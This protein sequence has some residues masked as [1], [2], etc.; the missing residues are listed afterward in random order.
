MHRLRG[1]QWLDL[2][3]IA[4]GSLAMCG[5]ACIF[6]S[7]ASFAA[8]DFSRFRGASRYLLSLWQGDPYLGGCGDG[9]SDGSDRG[10]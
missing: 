6:C 9:L 10:A 8:R 5:E 2:F 3:W 4:V 7:T 1:W